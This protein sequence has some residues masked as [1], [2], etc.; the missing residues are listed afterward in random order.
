[1]TK[2]EKAMFRAAKS[3]S[4][5]SDHPQH[6]L[7]CVVVN[8]HRIIS[9]GYNSKIKCHPLQAKIDTKRFG[10]ECKGC[11]HSETAALLPLIRDKVDLSKAAIFVYREHKD[12]TLAMARPCAG[13]ES[14]IRACGIKKIYYTVENA[15]KT[16][17]W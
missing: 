15:Y 12:G 6:K 16:E 17:K 14:L 7:G 10:C 3:M 4:E 5:L 9:T 1:M 13:C 11:I 2:T 8:K